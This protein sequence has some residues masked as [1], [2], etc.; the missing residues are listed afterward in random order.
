MKCRRRKELSFIRARRCH[1]I[2]LAI[3]LV[4]NFSGAAMGHLGP[5]DTETRVWGPKL[6]P[7]YYGPFW[8]AIQ[9]SLLP[10][11]YS[12]VTTHLYVGCPQ[13]HLQ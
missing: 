8:G 2:R 12:T 11:G 5:N 6:P 1:I 13:D 3:S 10:R 4:D 7:T 9:E